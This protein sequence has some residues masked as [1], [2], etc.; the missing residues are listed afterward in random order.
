[1]SKYS[2]S[3]LAADPQID[4]PKKLQRPRW[5]IV[6]AVSCFL[7]VL[8]IQ[9]GLTARANSCSWDEEDHIFAGYMMW[10]HADFGRNPEH[11]PLVKLLATI[12]LLRLPLTIPQSQD[13]FFKR[14]AF[15]TGREFLFNNNA[16]QIL[17]RTRMAASLLSLL[18]MVLV[19]LAAREMFGTAAGFI[20]LGLLVFDPTVVAHGAYVTTDMGLS[21]FMFGSIY[22]FYR[23][24]KAPSPRRL[25]G[26]GLVTGL[27]LASKH[28][29]IL[30]FPMLV[31]L[32]IYEA[33]RRRS[34]SEEI[35]P[36]AKGKRALR[37]AGALVLLSLIS[38]G[39]LWSFYGFRYQARPAGLQLNPPL[40]DYV[41]GLS[42]PRDVKI[43]NFVSHFR[44]LPESY[45]YGLADV[46]LTADFYATYVLGKDY[47]K[48]QW[49]YF[50]VAFAVKSSLTFLIMFVL[51]GWV[52]ASGR[53]RAWREILFLTV[54]PIVYFAVAM[55]SGMNI[56]VR[57]ILPVYIF[58]AVLLAGAAAKL[59]AANRRWLYVVLALLVFQAVSVVRT[60][61]AYVAYANELF[62]GPSQSYR[63]LSDSNVDWGQQLKSTKRYLDQNGIKDCWFVYFAAGVVDTDYYGIPCKPLPTADSLWLEN[64]PQAPPAIDGVVLISAG[65]L[66]GFEFG[67]GSLNP[68]EQFK[69]L[70]P[71]AVIDYGVF[72]FK[73]HFEIPLA[74]ALG[75]EQHAGTLRRAG[76]LPEALAE[77]Q[78]ALALAPS[79]VQMNNNLGDLLSATGRHDE[80]Q[81]AYARALHLA[82]TV[83]PEFQSGWVPDL[84][85]KLGNQK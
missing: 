16:D 66:S 82:Q 38:V 41:K 50:P 58:L 67:A 79:S 83:E 8:T 65:D 61:P 20:A 13:Q 1:M 3:D 73:G 63:Y 37:L 47:P 74:A 60:Y 34:P 39:V 75:H 24:V 31:L 53:L 72:V 85:K 70:Q 49:F 36:A 64:P 33:V 11:P 21:C 17:F 32:A 9:Y 10:K 51:T 6:A 7:V 2:R 76:K 35:V 71:I 14:D 81:Q 22:A 30:V 26:A 59:I 56:G 48:G 45:I 78:Q 23:Y 40:A 44:L 46:R 15:I 57:H 5:Q 27:A 19:F 43:L 42:R 28:S 77:E 54:P 52:I 4:S 62:G 80:A 25:M 68:Y 55:G 12:P 29:A 18:M 69:Q 84:E